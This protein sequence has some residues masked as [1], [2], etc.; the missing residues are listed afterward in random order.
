MNVQHY[1]HS[2]VQSECGFKVAGLAGSCFWIEN[3]LLDD[4]RT[5]CAAALAHRW[6]LSYDSI[7]LNP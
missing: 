3:L 4:A 7:V 2:S 6:F 1:Q 5:V